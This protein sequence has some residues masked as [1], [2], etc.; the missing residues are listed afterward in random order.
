MQQLETPKRRG[1]EKRRPLISYKKKR[2][3]NFRMRLF[4]QTGVN[5]KFNN[6]ATMFDQIPLFQFNTIL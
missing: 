1:V 2:D 4:T 5:Y 6:T 3:K